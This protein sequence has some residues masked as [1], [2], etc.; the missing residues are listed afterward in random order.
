MCVWVLSV[1]LT[2]WCASQV[3]GPEWNK[4]RVSAEELILILR[5]VDFE[6]FI[7]RDPLPYSHILG[8]LRT[9]ALLDEVDCAPALRR[10]ARF[11]G[12]SNL[13][14]LAVDLPDLSR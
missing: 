14:K 12:L 6:L 13:L 7:D 4:N 11:L 3:A 1:P 9:G 10:E 2:V 5:E 8:Y